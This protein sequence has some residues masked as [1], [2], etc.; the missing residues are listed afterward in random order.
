MSS[1]AQRNMGRVLR[2]KN[3]RAA[4]GN[5]TGESVLTPNDVRV[6][7]VDGTASIERTQDLG[8]RGVS[9]LLDQKR[10]EGRKSIMEME[11]MEMVNSSK[12]NSVSRV[13]NMRLEVHG[14]CPVLDPRTE[15]MKN[16]DVV[17]ALLLVYTAYVTPY[18]VAFLSTERINPLFVFN[19]FVDLCFICD[20]FRM[21]FTAYFDDAKFYFVT[22]HSMIAKNYFCGWFTIDLI[23]VLPFD[24]LGLVMDS[25]AMSQMKGARIVRLMRLLKLLRLLRSMRIFNRWQDKFG[26]SFALKSL[27]RFML[28]VLTTTHWMA[29]VLRL[30]PDLFV[31]TATGLEHLGL[32]D[33]PGYNATTG[34][35][36]AVLPTTISWLTEHSQPGCERLLDC[37]PS[38]QYTWALYWATMTL[39][40]IGYGDIVP[41]TVA[42]G[43]FVTMA[44]VVG[45]GLYAYIIGE[46]CGILANMDQATSEFHKNSDALNL[47][48]VEK[49]VPLSL[50]VRLREYLRN[51]KQL[52]R[53][54]HYRHLLLLYSPQL[55]GELT[56][57]L[58]GDKL[59]R[60]P[61]LN[62]TSYRERRD[63]I[64]EISLRMSHLLRAQQELIITYGSKMHCMYL[65]STGIAFSFVKGSLANKV[66]TSGKFF[67]VEGVLISRRF[68]YEVRALNYVQL[69]TIA[70]DDVDFIMWSGDYPETDRLIKR[71][72]IRLVFRRNLCRYLQ[73][74]LAKESTDI[75]TAF[76]QAEQ[77]YVCEGELASS[78]KHEEIH[79]GGGSMTDG[80]GSSNKDMKALGEIMQQQ[81][82]DQMQLHDRNSKMLNR[83]MEMMQQFESRIS[84]LERS[85]RGSS[86]ISNV[87][88]TDAPTDGFLM[89]GPPTAMMSDDDTPAT[90]RNSPSYSSPKSR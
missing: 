87:L 83:S 77:D 57:Y 79:L 71:A 19:R 64:K 16:W 23:S 30:I 86:P 52:Q 45:S 88:Q 21:F 29:C 43:V 18:E 6:H 80:G 31:Y 70:K 72:K 10:H 69:E 38:T 36:D 61:F 62:A 39:T 9:E 76:T 17:I 12:A 75:T 42:E 25:E 89:A 13:D 51:S 56:L 1:S 15:K 11:E 34:T 55:R 14:S 54:R 46:V 50:V 41:K 74:Q 60:V 47:F 65:V 32:E 49:Q 82:H 67:G 8:N 63:F 5:A 24:T 20:M 53:A 7:P 85:I 78:L 22:K 90:H 81:H 44:M 40:T 2:E 26:V 48:C 84:G 73:V 3:D 4:G 27:I 58:Y 33:M 35:A 66:Y 59:M 37:P 68:A 28:V